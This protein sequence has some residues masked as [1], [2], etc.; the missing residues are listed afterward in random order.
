MLKGTKLNNPNLFCGQNGFCSF[1][2]G[3]TALLGKNSGFFQ[4]W[5][6]ILSFLKVETILE[7]LNGS[8]MDGN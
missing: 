4:R 8:Y 5:Q 7:V 6:L 2:T 3:E 1:F